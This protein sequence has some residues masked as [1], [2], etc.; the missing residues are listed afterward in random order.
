ME[1]WS[2]TLSQSNAIQSSYFFYLV[3]VISNAV[4]EYLLNIHATNLLCGQI[5]GFMLR[6]RKLHTKIHKPQFLEQTQL[7]FAVLDYPSF[8]SC[9][10]SQIAFHA[11]EMVVCV[12]MATVSTKLH[13]TKL[14]CFQ[15]IVMSLEH[16]ELQVVLILRNRTAE[17]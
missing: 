6:R 16:G 14:C 5:L 8:D 3:T 12:P 7:P 11:H 15:R 1:L 13:V 2:C 9:L 4:I 10:H 17:R